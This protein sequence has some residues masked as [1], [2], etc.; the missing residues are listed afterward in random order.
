MLEAIHTG[1]L[2]G[3]IAGF[4]TVS[5]ALT[6]IFL[7][8]IIDLINWICNGGSNAGKGYEDY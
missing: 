5:T 4:A 7:W 3:I 6:I 8:G 2:W 1:L